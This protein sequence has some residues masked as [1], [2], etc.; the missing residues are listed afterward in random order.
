[1]DWEIT[2]APS[3][4]HLISNAWHCNISVPGAEELVPTSYNLLTARCLKEG[5][6]GEEE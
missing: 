2:F 4:P 1:M 3:P 5:S 6:D